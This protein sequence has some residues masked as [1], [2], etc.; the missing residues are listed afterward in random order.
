M[1]GIVVSFSDWYTP[2]SI[3]NL[4]HVLKLLN[5]T[6]L[7]L[8]RWP[9]HVTTHVNST[10]DTNHYI[11]FSLTW[12]SFS[13][14]L[15]RGGVFGSSSSF[16]PFETTRTRSWNK[17]VWLQSKQKIPPE[18][19]VHS[20]FIPHR[21]QMVTFLRQ[22]KKEDSQAFYLILA[23]LWVMVLWGNAAPDGSTF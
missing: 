15:W 23:S 5:V 9:T 17:E 19:W 21:V 18:C 6:S 10:Y 1:F 8:L 16:L 12:F 4:S 11:P 13:H 2:S 20:S 7:W 3:G 22:R 14:L